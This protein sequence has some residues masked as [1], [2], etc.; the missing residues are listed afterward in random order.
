MKCCW[1]E[2]TVIVTKQGATEQRWWVALQELQKWSKPSIRHVMRL[3]RL[4]HTVWTV[5]TPDTFGKRVRSAKIGTRA[6]LE[7]QVLN[8]LAASQV[9]SCGELVIWQE[10]KDKAGSWVFGCFRED[11]DGW[12]WIGFGIESVYTCQKLWWCFGAACVFRLF[13]GVRTDLEQKVSTRVK[14][15]FG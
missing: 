13:G 8:A 12:I 7:A 11:M 3:A 1:L 6:E 15:D 10:A 14:S 5:W 9:L 4:F 2:R